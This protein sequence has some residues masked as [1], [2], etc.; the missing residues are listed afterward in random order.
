MEVH[1]A[2]TAKE[3]AKRAVDTQKELLQKESQQAQDNDNNPISSLDL[4]LAL[5]VVEAVRADLASKT[6]LLKRAESAL[7]QKAK[8]LLATHRKVQQMESLKDKASM[9]TQKAAKRKEQAEIDDLATNREA[10]Q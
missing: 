5:A 6:E 4:Q 3:N 8:A 7:G 9:E 2:R 1:T 10:R